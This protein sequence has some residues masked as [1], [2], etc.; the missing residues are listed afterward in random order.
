MAIK[1]FKRVEN[2]FSG[3][4]KIKADS[5]DLQFNIISDYLNKDIKPLIDILIAGRVIGSNNPADSRKFLKNIGD[6]TTAWGYITLDSFCTNCISLEKFIK[7]NTGSIL[8]GNNLQV[9]TNVMP[10][11]N[12]QILTSK[13][14]NLPLWKKLTAD[15]IEDRGITGDDVADRTITNENLPAYLIETLIANNSITGDKFKNDSITSVKIDNQT[16]KA[17]K[18]S[19]ELALDFPSTVWENIIPN[20]YLTTAETI[21]N[22]SLVGSGGDRDRLIR[23]LQDKTQPNVAST[24]FAKV[25]QKTISTKFEASKFAVSPFNTPNENYNGFTANNLYG[26]IVSSTKLKANSIQAGRIAVRAV[27]NQQNPE[28]QSF[29]FRKNLCDLLADKSIGLEHL[30]AELRNKL[31]Q[32]RNK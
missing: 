29:Y 27:I 13:L 3:F 24:A 15:N 16:L 32:V 7:T 2:Y 8:S 1:P 30:I 19:P 20:S 26:T 21:L 6:G 31:N 4:K 25:G 23:T 11:E 5:I 9:L 28:Y 14:G 12:G 18:L 22:S 17:D 10:T